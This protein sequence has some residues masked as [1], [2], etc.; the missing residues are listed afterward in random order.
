MEVA[1]QIT[2]ERYIRLIEYASKTC[3]AAMFVTRQDK[4]RLDSFQNKELIETARL[5]EERLKASFIKKRTTKQWVHTGYANAPNDDRIG[6][7]FYRFSAEVKR[8]LLTNDDLYN[9]LNP[10]HPEDISL[11]K[12]GYCWLY[13]VAHEEMCDIYC[14]NEEEYEYLKSI[15]IEFYEDKFVPTPKEK[16]YYEDYGINAD[17][18]SIS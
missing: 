8:F 17:S 15:G 13:S 2:G 9:W 12:D 5:F 1:N 14:R 18:Q 10:E 6:V 11:F 7:Y 3:D 4:F 16:L